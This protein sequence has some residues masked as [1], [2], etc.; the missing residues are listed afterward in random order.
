MNRSDASVRGTSFFLAEA[1]GS[2][3][4]M[5]AAMSLIAIGRSPDAARSPVPSATPACPAAN[6]DSLH[7]R[8]T[9]GP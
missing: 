1:L 6:L 9:P 8:E 3:I 2:G 4:L 7:C 5:I